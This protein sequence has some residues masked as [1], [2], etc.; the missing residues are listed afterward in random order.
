MGE[1]EKEIRSYFS[2]TFQKHGSSPQGLDWNSKA[3][4]YKRLG[5]IVSEVNA[6]SDFSI[7]DVGCGFGSL[8]DCLFG[9][10]KAE[11]SYQGYD[12]VEE[13]VKSARETWCDGKLDIN[14]TS[15]GT[16]ALAM[17]DFTIASG[18]FNMKQS[19]ST[20]DWH[21]YV[22]ENLVKMLAATRKRIIVNFL[23]GYSDEEFKR[24]DL[25]YPDPKEMLGFGLKQTGSAAIRHNYG[26]YDFTLVVDK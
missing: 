14:F 23:T 13:M 17:A 11:F 26:L 21:A 20:E 5:V 16:D 2:A 6:T 15:G 3:A 7:N 8:L 25:Y 4:H 10:G 12:L 9:A 22:L 19:T 18:T 24:D 1:I